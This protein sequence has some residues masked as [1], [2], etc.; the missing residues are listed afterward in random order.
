MIS[1]NENS[2]SDAFLV[3]EFKLLNQSGD[4]NIGITNDISDEGLSL[5]TQSSSDLKKGALLEIYLK[6][7]GN[8][9]RVCIEGIVIWTKSSWYKFIVGIKFHGDDKECREE[10]KKLISTIKVEKKTETLVEETRVEESIFRALDTLDNDAGD[11]KIPIDQPQGPEASADI[12]S[13]SAESKDAPIEDETDE[14]EGVKGSDGSDEQEEKTDGDKLL[15]DSLLATIED[16]PVKGSKLS[17]R[18]WPLFLT[19][20]AVV[21]LLMF[22]LPSLLKFTNRG[23]EPQVPDSAYRASDQS[24]NNDLFAVKYDGSELNTVPDP[25][26]LPSEFRGGSTFSVT[27]RS[28]NELIVV[29]EEPAES[30]DDS[31]VSE[32]NREGNPFAVLVETPLIEG[33]N[34]S[35]IKDE[36]NS[37]S[38]PAEETVSRIPPQNKEQNKY[39]V[40]AHTLNIRARASV[41][42]SIIGKLKRGSVVDVHESLENGEGL[43]HRVDIGYVFALYTIELIPEQ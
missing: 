7:S 18:R 39:V 2:M 5:E 31:E 16:H 34:K 35:L 1:F 4:Y 17:G 9:K 24:E 20:A 26:D 41:E 11:D 19:V 23:R 43:W 38:E 33:S 32:V 6:H 29:E 13:N 8:D 10:L 40:S 12:T 30:K 22:V 15:L 42:S 21:I 25:E 36:V 14:G 27:H 3:A 37:L 28:E